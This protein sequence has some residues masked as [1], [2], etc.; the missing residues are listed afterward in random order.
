MVE[1]RLRPHHLAA[2]T[3]AVVGDRVRVLGFG[4]GCGCGFGCG[5]EFGSLVGPQDPQDLA[6][7][8][9]TLTP[10]LTLTLT[11]LERK[12]ARP[13]R[14]SDHGAVELD[15]QVAGHVELTRASAAA[16]ACGVAVGCVAVGCETVRARC[17]RIA[18][19]ASRVQ[20]P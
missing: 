20:R 8:T 17:V 4:F 7:S 15:W 9:L 1:I 6:A 16:S 11:F 19:V 18:R 3:P 14:S 12:P 10:T 5:F 2:S 13:E